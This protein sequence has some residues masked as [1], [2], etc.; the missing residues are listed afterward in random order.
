MMRRAIISLL[1]PLAIATGCTIEPP[2]HLRESIIAELILYPQMDVNVMW[3]PEWEDIWSFRWDTDVL[4]PLGYTTPTGSRAHIY[5][6]DNNG[7]HTNH[8][9]RNFY[10]LTDQFPV[11]YGKYDFLY[12]NNDSEALLFSTAEGTEDDVFCYTR[13]ISRG[14]KGSSPLLTVQQKAAATKSD[15]EE[16][17]V[18]EPVALMPDGLFSQYDQ[19]YVISTDLTK[20][21]YI[22][23]KY[24]IRIESDIYPSTYIHLIEIHLH[25]NYDRIIGSPGGAAVTGVAD[26]VNV[27]TRISDTQTVTVPMDVYMDKEKDMMGARVL[28]FGIPGCNPYDV[29]SVESSS[30]RHFLVLNVAYINGSYRNVR[31]DITDKFRELPLGGVIVL[32]LDVN[33]FP[34]DDQGSLG[35][36]VALIDDW[37]EETGNATIIN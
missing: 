12:H 8:V 22:N 23:G 11:F 32:D 15:A 19:D 16:V 1:I 13:T 27:N 9:I 2:L 26:G 18:D 6:T 36:F 17:D 3:Q 20:Y 4:G 5:S 29:A 7:R 21:Q 37:D 10:G 34:P 28:T 30:S 31:I 14:L 33:D 24:V 35:G 25:N